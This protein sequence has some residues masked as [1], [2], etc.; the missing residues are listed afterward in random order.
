MMWNCLASAIATANQ[1][2]IYNTYRNYSVDF[3]TNR[4]RLN[5]PWTLKHL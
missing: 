3:G 4:T 5:N 2:S 1:N